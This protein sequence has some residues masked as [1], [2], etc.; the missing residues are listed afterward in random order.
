VLG[1]HLSRL[2]QLRQVKRTLQAENGR[3]RQNLPSA[4]DLVGDSPALQQL[5]R[6]IAAAAREAAPVLL[7]GEAGTGKELVAVTIH[8]QGPRAQGPL[9]VVNCTAIPPA[10]LEGELFGS[11]PGGLAGAD[12]DCPGRVEEADA[13]PLV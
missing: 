8:R 13:C 6:Q 9:V 12:R 3:L 4:D 10:Q 1:G 5:R 2:L 11:A 7:T